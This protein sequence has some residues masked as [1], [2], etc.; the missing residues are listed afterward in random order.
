MAEP[1]YP[2][3]PPIRPEPEDPEGKWVQAPDQPHWYIQQNTVTKAY[4]NVNTPPASPP[5]YNP[6]S[7]LPVIKP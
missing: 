7:G 5:P 6:W 1:Y 4:R 3:G 2:L